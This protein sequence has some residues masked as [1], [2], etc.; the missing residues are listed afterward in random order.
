MRRALL[1]LALLTPGA[2][3]ACQSADVRSVVYET[4]SQMKESAATE[5]YQQFADVNGGVVSIGCFVVQKRQLDCFDT[6][7]SGQPNLRLGVVECECPCEAFENDPCDVSRRQ[8]R[9]GVIRGLVNETQGPLQ[10]GGVEV[11]TNLV[12]K[13]ASDIFITVESNTD[14]D[15]SPSGNL[16]LKGELLK[17][18]TVLRG[19]LKTATTQP[20]GGT[21]A[22][23][24]V[25]DE[26]SL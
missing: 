16:L 20:I 25:E 8:V 15:P 14:A 18:G 19:T 23:L 4:F 3:G 26:V 21:V 12:L 2:L 22:I 10:L 9:S 5:H 11:P 17:D 6:T 7:S 24:P 13:Q 1:V